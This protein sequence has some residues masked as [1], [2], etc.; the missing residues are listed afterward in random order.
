MK[1]YIGLII[2]SFGIAIIIGSN[3][4]GYTAILGIISVGLGLAILYDLFFNE[5][6]RAR[7]FNTSVQELREL[8][9]NPETSVRQKIASNPNTPKNALKELSNDLDEGVRENVAFHSNTSIIELHKL[10]NDSNRRV[11]RAVASN[12]NL[13]IETLENLSN[14]SDHVIR[15]KAQIRLGKNGGKRK[16]KKK[17]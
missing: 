12:S 7:N 9:N 3:S 2:F 14:D 1:L 8:S 10:S 6:Q 16:T 11:R 13:S 15:K 5:I 4:F 17:K